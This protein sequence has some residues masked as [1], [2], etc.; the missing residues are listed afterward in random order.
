[1]KDEKSDDILK[2]TTPRSGVEAMRESVLKQAKVA[3]HD[4]DIEDQ[5]SR[6]R[7][8]T[9]HLGVR[10]TTLATARSAWRKP[11]PMQF[12]MR[13]L[14]A[15][16]AT[17]TF[18]AWGAWYDSCQKSSFES[19]PLYTTTTSAPS[20][21]WLAA[22]DLDPDARPLI[23]V[24]PRQGVLTEGATITWLKARESMLTY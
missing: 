10:Q 2:Q 4:H 14:L 22:L 5:L 7:I 6:C 16:A 11:A 20:A 24:S 15:T 13:W 1:M 21:S 23:G 12:P 17:V 9:P 3:W 19:R 18:A 8:S